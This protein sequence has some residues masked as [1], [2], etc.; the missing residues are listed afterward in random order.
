MYHLLPQYKQQGFT[1]VE[2]IVIIIIIGIL[3]ASVSSRF[4]GSS[5]YA[6]YTYQARLIAALRNMQQRAMQDTRPGYCF[7][8]NFSTSPSSD[9]FG[10]PTLSYNPGGNTSDTCSNTIDHG[11]SDY[12]STSASEMNDE[13]VTFASLPFAF[14]GFDDLGRP[15]TDNIN[16]A[17]CVSTCQVDFVGEQTVSVCVESQ[18][19]IHV[20]P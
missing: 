3:A 15:L 2:L 1:L 9:A 19:Y 12:L 17:N 4:S 11:N 10:P 6:E 8:I 16:S 18:G 14:I 20:C 5:G 13:G 7:Q